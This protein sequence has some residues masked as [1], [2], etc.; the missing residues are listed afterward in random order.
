MRCRLS[1][2]EKPA[3]ETEYDDWLKIL[4]N[5]KS[6]PKFKKATLEC[7]TVGAAWRKPYETEYT[8]AIELAYEEPKKNKNT[9]TS[10][11]GFEI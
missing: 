7:F 9:I 11:K 6:K 8:D 4:P 10:D 5:P 2:S 3:N 1:A